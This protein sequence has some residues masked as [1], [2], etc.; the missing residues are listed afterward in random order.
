MLIKTSFFG[1]IRRPWPEQSKTV[2][3]PPGSTVENLLVTLG[4]QPE[5]MRRV[6]VVI[7][8]ARKSLSTKL[9]EDDDVRF[10]LLAG[11]G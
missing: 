5:D 11:G 6:A 1:P 3:T 9:T 2:E 10:V 7:N 8:G 4:Y